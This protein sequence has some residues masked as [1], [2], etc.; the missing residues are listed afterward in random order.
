MDLIDRQTA[1]DA[2]KEWEKRY[3]WDDWCRMHQDEKEEYNI[4]AP[5]D[6]ISK[7]PSAKSDPD[8]EFWENRAAEYSKIIASLVAD[9]SKGINFKSMRIT[10]TGKIIFGRTEPE[11]SDVAR[12][13]ATII[14]NE[15]DM[16]VIAEPRKGKWIWDDEGYHCSECF[17][18]AHGNTLEC[19][20]GTYR[21]CPNCGADMRGE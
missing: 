19:L 11:P 3:V 7:L 16:R 18:H 15:K 9:M 6:V 5:S 10:E 8:A 2:A 13:I 21:F 20:D 17:F 4:T 12:D 14:E 1:I